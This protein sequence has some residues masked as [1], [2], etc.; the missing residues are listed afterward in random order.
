MATKINP[1]VFNSKSKPYE[2]YK[3]ELLAWSEITELAKEK[4][5]I[6]IILHLLY[7]KKMKPKFE[8]KFLNKSSLKI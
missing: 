1:P 5:G 4:K 8:R 3:H 2:L 7:L 6:A